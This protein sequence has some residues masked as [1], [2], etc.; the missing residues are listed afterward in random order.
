MNKM[1]WIGA[2][3]VVIAGGYSM[4]YAAALSST[5]SGGPADFKEIYYAARCQLQHSDPYREGV[6]LRLYQEDGGV[7]PSEPGQSRIFRRSVGTFVYTPSSFFLVTPLALLPLKTAEAIWLTLLGAVICLAAFLMWDLGAAYAPLLSSVLVSI[8]LTGCELIFVTGNAAGLVIGLC[9]IAV[10]CFV[11]ERF[12][13]AGVFCLAVSLALKPHD[14]GLVWLF[15]LLAGGTYRRRALQ[16]LAV[17]AVLC[18][19]ACLWISHVAPGWIGELHSNLQV[20][21]A[22]GDINDPG[23]AGLDGRIPGAIVDLQGVVS[24]FRDQPQFYNAVS[25]LLCGSLLIAW[26]IKALR[27]QPTRESVLLAVAC[28]APLTMLPTYHRHHD[29]KLLILAIP[30]CSML[31]A[32]GGVRRWIACIATTGGVFFTSDL[33]LTVFHVLTRSFQPSL[34][35]LPNRIV[36]AAIIRPTPSAL[37]VMSICLLWIYLRWPAPLKTRRAI[38]DRQLE[39]LS[40]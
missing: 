37:L 23:P 28:I 21:S 10:W 22:R 5:R 2:A 20:A 6:I 29:A 36:T 18:L 31:W 3:L 33:S 38:Q 27:S 12:V 13:W 8:L 34:D 17:T 7:I 14:V 40:G 19:P 11:R 26:S 24:I 4:F 9:G 39:V 1:R 15:F 35:T 25:L 16:T 32:S 30:A